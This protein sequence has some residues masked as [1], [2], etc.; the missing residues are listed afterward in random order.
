MVAVIFAN[1]RFLY[2]TSEHIG[3]RVW[4]RHERHGTTM[5]SAVIDFSNHNLLGRVN[6]LTIL[7]Q[8]AHT[9]RV[10]CGSRL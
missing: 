1:A 4:S 7:A 9:S 6:F 10:I 3:L 2:R 5:W 8:G